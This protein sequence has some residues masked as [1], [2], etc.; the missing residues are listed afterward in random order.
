MQNYPNPFNPSTEI[1]FGLPKEEYV[2]VAVYNILGEKIRTLAEGN[3][4]EGY[5]RFVWNAKD[6]LGNAVAPGMYIYRLEGN[7]QT[8]TKKMILLK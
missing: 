5:H 4:G 1:T 7:S 6:E 3:F 8:M 2:T